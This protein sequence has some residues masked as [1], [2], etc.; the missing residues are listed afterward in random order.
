MS[1]GGWRR[2]E[3][4][5]QGG[6]VPI[7]SALERLRKDLG[8]PAAD[9]SARLNSG[10][11]EALGPLVDHLVSAQLRRD[12]V[13]LVVNDPSIAQAVRL[14]VGR[15]VEELARAEPPLVVS[16]VRVKVDRRGRGTSR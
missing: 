4:R 1:P 12:V 8:V 13:T 16:D 10:L 11:R 2:G 3:G 6:P 15:V 7:S 9:A 14:R 5:G